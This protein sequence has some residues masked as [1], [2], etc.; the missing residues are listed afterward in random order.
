MPLSRPSAHPPE[1]FFPRSS[2]P[3]L[4][5]PSLPRPSLPRA[6]H[7]PRA[8]SDI[9]ARTPPSAADEVWP[10]DDR[11]GAYLVGAAPSRGRGEEEEEVPVQRFSRVKSRVSGHWARRTGSY[12]EGERGKGSHRV[13][14]VVK[15]REGRRCLTEIETME[16]NSCFS[17][18]NT[19][20]E[21]GAK[22]EGEIV[23]GYCRMYW[24]AGLRCTRF[25]RL[26]RGQLS[27]FDGALRRRIWE[28]VLD[29][30]RVRVQTGTH[31]GSNKI[32]LSKLHCGYLIEFYLYDAQS[33][34]DWG[35]ALLRAS[36]ARRQR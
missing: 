5:R 7:P 2:L 3:P 13:E 20:A 4:P 29:G 32:V 23:Q 25:L 24:F 18:A 34:R 17:I 12:Y 21:E 14:R 33:C 28:V 26:V 30:A 27:C 22:R 8:V 36:I 19:V 15:R 1:P 9:F 31:T 11:P 6:E 16:E 35:A 10:V